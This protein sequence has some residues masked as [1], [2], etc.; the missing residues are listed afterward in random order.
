MAEET[1]ASSANKSMG[2]LSRMLKEISIRRRLRLPEIFKGLRLKSEVAN[3]RSPFETDFIQ[4]ELL[5]KVALDGLNEDARLILYVLADTGLRPSEVVNLLPNAIHLDAAIPYVEI[6]PE[7]RVLKTE[8]SRREIPL[9]GAALAAMKLRP[10]GFPRYRDK[11]SSLSAA[12][13]KYL[14]EN[15]LRPTKGHT[16]YSLRPSSAVNASARCSPGS[17][18]AKDSRRWGSQRS[19]RLCVQVTQQHL[20]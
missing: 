14:L 8:D 17:S 4:E 5:A 7:G 18:V 10:E 13:N 11:S 16:V 1:H 19:C 12:V 15:G 3:I 2:M 9:V 20:W 6:L